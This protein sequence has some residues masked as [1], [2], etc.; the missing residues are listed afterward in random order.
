MST[1]PRTTWATG[2]VGAARRRGGGF[3]VL[4][5]VLVLAIIGLLAT[6]TL[7]AGA[8]LLRSGPSRPDD[9]FLKACQTARKM[10]F[11]SGREV[12]L[13]YDAKAK[14][15]VCDDGVA[16]ASLPVP[17]P[18]ADL[19]IDLHPNQASTSNLSLVG[20][21]AVE[22]QPIPYATFY[23][24]GTCFPFHAQFRSKGG[25]HLLTIDPWTCA[26]LLAPA[27]AHAP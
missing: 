3:T 17:N 12:R 1:A 9:V 21:V 27:P 25:A 4:E 2:D 8:H 19:E 14:A 26:P 22:G 10:A 24:D 11:S 6:L 5:L 16:P 20:G 23:V 13:S 15:F 7:G 18:S